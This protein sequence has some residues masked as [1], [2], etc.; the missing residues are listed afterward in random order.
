MGGR[1]RPE[2]PEILIAPAAR[3]IVVIGAG[4]GGLWA[5]R[6]FVSH[7][8]GVTLID[9]NNYHTFFPLLYQ[10]AAAELGP[11]EIAYPIRSLFRRHPLV[12]FRR[13]NVHNI[14][15]D[16]RIVEAGES[17]LEYDYLVMAP[18]SVPDFFAVEGAARHAFPLRTMDDAIPLRYHVLNCFERAAQTSGSSTRESLLRFVI[19]GGGPTGVE[20]AGALAELIYGPLLKDFGSIARDEVDIRLLEGGERLLAGM[21]PRL[22]E[23][24]HVR[25]E[26]RGVQVLTGSRVVEVASD[27]VVTCDTGDTKRRDL[28]D[29]MSEHTGQTATHTVVWAAGVQG[30]PAV[31]SWGLPVG[32]GGRV[33]VEGTLQV[34]GYPEVCVVGDLAYLEVGGEALPQTAQV[35]LQQGSTAAENVVLMIGGGGTRRIHLQGSGHVGRD[36][37]ER[38]GCASVG[39]LIH[40]FRGLDAV[41]GRSRRKPHG[42]SQSG[43]RPRELGLELRVLPAGGAP[44][45]AGCNRRAPCRQAPDGLGGTVEAHHRFSRRWIVWIVAKEGD[46][47]GGW[48]AL[49]PQPVNV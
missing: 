32:P 30:D 39:A 13:A 21:P 15:L 8:I 38:G 11:S 6:R 5:V 4:F 3:R 19:V 28:G 18:G 29:V 25:L 14:D 17:R 10:V 12:D 41:A 23:Y 16:A 46:R 9:R 31:G 48:A 36:R 49:P 33:P 40:R 7:G 42:L 47:Q 44:D 24:A 43:A 26:R 34:P 1:D 22:Q 37:P 2:P 45:S 27:R 35:A 20:Y